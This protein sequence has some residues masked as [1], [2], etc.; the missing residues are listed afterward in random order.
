MLRSRSVRLGVQRRMGSKWGTPSESF[1]FRDF[2]SNL[3]S[4]KK[5]KE[6]ASTISASAQTPAADSS[7]IVKELQVLNDLINDE[8]KVQ[9]YESSLVSILR[10]LGIQVTLQHGITA[11]FLKDSNVKELIE[12]MAEGQTTNDN[13]YKFIFQLSA[14][15]G[16]S[17]YHSVAI[18]LIEKILQEEYHSNDQTNIIN[19][20][21]RLAFHLNSVDRFEDSL[22]HSL[23]VIEESP[24]ADICCQAM[25]SQVMLNKLED[26]VQNY[27]KLC[28]LKPSI[29]V[30]E[31]ADAIYK[32]ASS[33]LAQRVSL[34]ESAK[35]SVKLHVSF[36][37]LIL[38]PEFARYQRSHSA[39]ETFVFAA[40]ILEHAASDINH[41]VVL[42]IPHEMEL[43]PS[44]VRKP[45]KKI[46]NEPKEQTE[47]QEAIKQVNDESKEK[48]QKDEKEDA[49][50]GQEEIPKKTVEQE[51]EKEADIETED[52]NGFITYEAPKSSEI[53]IRD[54]SLNEQEIFIMSDSVTVRTCNM[55]RLRSDLSPV[56]EM[57]NAFLWE[58]YLKKYLP[59]PPVSDAPKIWTAKMRIRVAM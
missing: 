45:Q 18:T 30:V 17:S 53:A 21:K 37:Q 57:S 50:Q 3:F 47:Q 10:L 51:I 44:E 58:K 31:S 33:V 22:Q 39:Q 42:Y 36:N 20:R 28:K 1:S 9:D 48:T 43:E 2:A 5:K 26:C 14:T 7:P 55:A 41:E 6:A 29:T 49:E 25:Y 11:P 13:I 15:A 16:Q 24:S 38:I 12:E 35:S 32:K 27:K 23:F 52:N 8:D 4:G 59:P 46:P 40:E 19:C 34:L 54:A 56:Y